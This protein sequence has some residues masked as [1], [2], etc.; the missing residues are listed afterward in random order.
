MRISLIVLSVINI[1]YMF[2]TFI[3][4]DPNI[5]FLAPYGLTYYLAFFLALFSVGVLIITKSSDGRDKNL[6]LVSMIINI[7]GMFLVKIFF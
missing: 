5:F 4:N 3:I 7:V 2:T 1:I 6:L